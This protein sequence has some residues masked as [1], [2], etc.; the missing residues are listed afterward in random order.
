VNALAVSLLEGSRMAD[1][2]ADAAFTAFAREQGPRLVR[3]AT[4]VT[5]SSADGEDAAQEA[6]L[7]LARAWRRVRPETAP[8][9]ARRIVVRKSLDVVGRRRDRTM[10]EVPDIAREDPGLLAYEEDRAF[11]DRLRLLPVGQRA[12]L[13]LRYYADL[14]DRTIGRM[15][16]TR[17]STVRS[18]AARGLAALRAESGAAR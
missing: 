2:S 8:A 9:Y 3:L 18:Q 6:L 12:V 16:G 13:V 14:D 1:W 5:G 15:L 7:S 4:L 17:E 10:G 11:F